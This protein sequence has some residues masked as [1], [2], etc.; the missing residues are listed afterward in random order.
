MTTT[1]LEG[2]VAIINDLM[3]KPHGPWRPLPYGLLAANIGHY[4]V[5]TTIEGATLCQITDEEGNTRDVFSCGLVPKRE[6]H[7]R[8]AAYIQGIQDTQAAHL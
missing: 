7:N 4:Y 3:G 2:T 1:R 6:L 5:K 8:M